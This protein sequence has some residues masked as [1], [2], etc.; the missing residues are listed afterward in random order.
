MPVPVTSTLLITFWSLLNLPTPAAINWL[1]SNVIVTEPPWMM[2]GGSPADMVFSFADEVNGERG[3][4]LPARAG[5]ILSTVSRYVYDFFSV[6]VPQSVAD[7]DR[8]GRGWHDRFRA[9]R[10]KNGRA[11]DEGRARLSGLRRY[12]FGVRTGS[13]RRAASGRPGSRG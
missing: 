11:R 12:A 3:D 6:R 2:I 5:R 7:R 8:R 9:A 13:A 1:A 10:K 4:G